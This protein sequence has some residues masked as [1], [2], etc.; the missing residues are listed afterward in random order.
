MWG[1]TDMKLPIDVVPNSSPL[2]F[3]WTQVV[4]TLTGGRAVQDCEGQL[5]PS[6]E[7]AVEKLVAV[8]KGALLDNAALRGQ[9]DSLRKRLDQI[10]KDAKDRVVAAAPLK[11]QT[12][13]TTPTNKK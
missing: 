8:A 2:I 4:G 7:R 10:D 9:L 6:C 12:A 13:P 3:K 11:P 5:P 1:G